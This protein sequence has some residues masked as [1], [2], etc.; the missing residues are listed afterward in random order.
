MSDIKKLQKQLAPIFKKND[1]VRSS[2]FG[3]VARG[4]DKPNSDIDILVEFAEGKT[5]LDLVGLEMEIEEKLGK[6]IDLLT[7]NSIH[8]LLKDYIYKDEIKIYG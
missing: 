2:V 7:Y 4:E 5:L 1:V 3:S 6:K 8:P